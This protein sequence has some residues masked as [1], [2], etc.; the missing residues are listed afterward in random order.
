[1]IRHEAVRGNREVF[2]ACCPSDLCE[3]EIDGLPLSKQR[4]PGVAAERQKVPM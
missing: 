2:V 4:L 1:M 3:H